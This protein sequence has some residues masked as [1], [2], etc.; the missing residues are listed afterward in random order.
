MVVSK[1][2]FA[3]VQLVMHIAFSSWGSRFLHESNKIAHGTEIT[4][5]LTLTSMLRRAVSSIISSRPLLR[6]KDK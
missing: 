4:E 1:Y 6:M 5:R 3:Y 2:V